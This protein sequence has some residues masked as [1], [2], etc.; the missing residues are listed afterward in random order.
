M[1][2]MFYH[3]WP[4]EGVFSMASGN[5]IFTTGN[6][7]VQIERKH[8]EVTWFNILQWE[9]GMNSKKGG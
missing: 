7:S 2:C 9:R 1:T 3:K 5:S 6:I 4:A 8:E